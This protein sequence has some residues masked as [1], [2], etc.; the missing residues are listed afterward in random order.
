MTN[1]EKALEQIIMQKHDGEDC[2]IEFEVLEF[3]ESALEEN[4]KLKA[5]IEQL[6]AELERSVKMPCKV[7]DVV[8]DNDFG[9][10]TPSTIV[11]YSFGEVNQDY[12]LENDIEQIYLYSRSNRYN[13]DMSFPISCIG[14]SIFLTREEA[15]QH[16]KGKV[17][18]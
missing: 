3:L 5:E 15:E 18:E 14:E 7:G 16:L 17:E 2:L 8:Y 1:E 11:G 6:K 10:P 12:D 9:C 4:S 13:I